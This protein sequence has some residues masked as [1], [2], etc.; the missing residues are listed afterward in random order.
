MTKAT[1]AFGCKQGDLSSYRPQSLDPC[2]IECLFSYPGVPRQP[3]T[4]EIEYHAMITEVAIYA[5]KLIR[6]SDDVGLFFD[7]ANDPIEDGLIFLDLAAWKLPS[8]S[9]CSNQ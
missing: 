1:E 5:D 9:F 6:R 3:R 4:K 8:P 2:N 7:L